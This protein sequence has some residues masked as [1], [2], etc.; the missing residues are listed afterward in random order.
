MQLG[1]QE[2]V[3]ESIKADVEALLAHAAGPNL[4][5]LEAQFRALQ[6]MKKGQVGSP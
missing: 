6:E 5:Q 3:Y 4:D 2:E 1:R